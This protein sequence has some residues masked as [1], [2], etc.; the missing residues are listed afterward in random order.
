MPQRILRTI[1][2]HYCY[3]KA[4]KG[5]R[6]IPFGSR[7]LDIGMLPAIVR[8]KLNIQAKVPEKAGN[9]DLSRQICLIINS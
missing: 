6:C 4:V 3:S 1:S 5:M 7:L 2:K 9:I 8:R